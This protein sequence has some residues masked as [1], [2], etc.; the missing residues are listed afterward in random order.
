MTGRYRAI[1]PFFLYCPYLPLPVLFCFFCCLLC[2]TL[3]A[4]PAEES[5]EADLLITEGREPELKGLAHYIFVEEDR[6]FHAV[7]RSTN[8]QLLESETLALTGDGTVVWLR[9]R[10]KNGQQD[11]LSMYLRCSVGW[12]ESVIFYEMKSAD[13]EGDLRIQHAGTSARV[14]HESAH[15]AFR[16]SLDQAETSTIYI[17]LQSAKR[18]STDFRIM[19]QGRFLEEEIRIVRDTGLFLGVVLMLMVLNALL[20]GGFRDR[21]ISL[22]MLWILSVGIY[23]IFRSRLSLLILP[24][25]LAA[26]SE[27]FHTV[28]ICFLAFSAIAFGRSFL[29]LAQHRPVMDRVATG[30]QFLSCLPVALIPFSASFAR[31]LVSYTEFFIGPP[32]LIFALLSVRFHRSESYYF[33]FAWSLP[34]GAAMLEHFASLDYFPLLKDRELLPGALLCEFVIFALVLRNRIQKAHRIQVTNQSRLERVDS[35]LGFARRIQREF[36]PEPQYTSVNAEIRVH[37]EPERQVG[38]D[39]CDVVHLSQSH[40]GLMV[41]DVTG[42][43]MSAALDAALVRL[44]FRSV[45]RD[46]E[47]PAEVLEAMNEFL[48][49]HLDYKFVSVIYSVLDTETGQGTVALAG[50]PPAVLIRKDGASELLDDDNCMLGIAPEM[51]ISDMHFQLNSGDTLLLYTDGL[52]RQESV[53]LLHAT[54]NVMLG[55]TQDLNSDEKFIPELLRRA[56]EWRQGPARDDIAILACSFSSDTSGKR[57]ATRQGSL[58]S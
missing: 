1:L 24:P 19:S 37:Y 45:H 11:F 36:M 20:Y 26:H 55:L 47:S 54:G 51:Q 9:L 49:P 25:S 38:G 22:Y 27:I 33:L 53:D 29:R 35:E 46:S 57:G 50:H 48:F 10:V 17:R 13:G 41:A 4:R 5:Q 42:H 30:F 52:I 16:I 34:I 40:V 44:A 8:W 7:R 43:G 12:P 58:V 31:E 32:L 15:P 23:F 21:S 18:V 2:S 3:E 56:Q 39:Y 14:Q 6:D 28:S